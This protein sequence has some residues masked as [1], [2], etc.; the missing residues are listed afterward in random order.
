MTKLEQLKE[1]FNGLETDH[2]TLGDYLNDNDLEN[3]LDGGDFDTAFEAIRENGGV[4]VEVIYYNNAIKLLQ[5]EDP[6]LNRALEI[7]GEL[8]F[9]TENLNSEVLASLLASEI[10]TEQIRE[11]E[12]EINDFLEN[13]EEE[14]D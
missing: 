12:T 3:I 9:S 2:I 11:F 4:D 5:R 8:G 14:E 1:F 6:S 10:N 13:L 7:A